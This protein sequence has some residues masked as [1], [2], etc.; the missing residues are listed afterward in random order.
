MCPSL[1]LTL[2]SLLSFATWF[3]SP[4]SFHMSVSFILCSVSVIQ[5]LFPD[6]LDLC[7][8]SYLFWSSSNSSS[9]NFFPLPCLQSGI[10]HSHHSIVAHFLRR[11]LFSAAVQKSRQNS[12]P[13]V[14]SHLKPRV[15]NSMCNP[16]R[17]RVDLILQ[18]TRIRRGINQN[19][20]NMLLLL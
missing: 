3:I 15:C 11:V 4:W 20:R 13:N 1:T 5:P 17:T 7:S 8:L 14:K 10:T 16:K 9:A 6:L 19:V 12:M 18:K 2:L